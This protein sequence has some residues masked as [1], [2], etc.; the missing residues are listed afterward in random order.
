MHAPRPPTA[1][2]TP[3][4]LPHAPRPDIEAKLDELMR[5]DHPAMKLLHMTADIIKRDEW[6]GGYMGAA[7]KKQLLCDMQVSNYISGTNAN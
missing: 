2:M 7:G 3:A 1:R 5:G 4:H 6:C